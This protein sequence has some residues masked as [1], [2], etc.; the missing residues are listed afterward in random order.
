[1]SNNHWQT[2]QSSTSSSTSTVTTIAIKSTS[3]ED[4]YEALKASNHFKLPSPPT[5]ATFGDLAKFKDKNGKIL[6]PSNRWLLF[7]SSATKALKSHSFVNT[8]GEAVALKSIGM[9]TLAGMLWGALGEEEKNQWT[10]AAQALNDLHA[11]VYPDYKFCPEKK[12]G[13]A[14]VTTLA[15]LP[16]KPRRNKEKSVRGVSVA[17]SNASSDGSGSSMTTPTRADIQGPFAQPQQ[18]SESQTPYAS[19][20]NTIVIGSSQLRS[21]LNAPTSP[22]FGFV[23]P[24]SSAPTQPFAGGLPSTSSNFNVEPYFYMNSTDWSSSHSPV[25]ELFGTYPYDIS[26]EP[27]LSVLEE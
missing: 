4:I 12:H 6:R 27:D 8:K 25:S 13:G 17:L 5:N 26:F 24:T 10:L 2:Q 22:H 21:L 11:E 20:L 14:Q 9:S 3:P 1:M 7:L 16:P 19:P 23:E 18:F 15:P